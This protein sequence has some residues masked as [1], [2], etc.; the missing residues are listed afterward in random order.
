MTR[1]RNRLLHSIGMITFLLASSL[2]TQAQSSYSITDLGIRGGAGLN[3]LGQ[4]TGGVSTP[5]GVR[6]YRWTDA[7]Y[8][9]IAEASEFLHLSI[10]NSYGFATARTYFQHINNM[11]QVAGV[12]QKNSTTIPEFGYVWNAAGTNGTILTTNLGIQKV[13]TEAFGINDT[14]DVVGVESAHRSNGN[15]QSPIFW[16]LTGASYTTLRI[17]NLPGSTAGYAWDVNN[18]RQVVGTS[19]SNA[20]VWSEAAGLTPLGRLAGHNGSTGVNAIN[21]A[22]Y[23]VGSTQ[24]A[25]LPTGN[26]VARAYL[27]LPG[28]DNGTDFTPYD[29]GGAWT[30]SRASDIN[31]VTTTP[32]S[33]GVQI[34]FKIAG[35][36]WGGSGTAQAVIWDVSVTRTS[37][38]QSVNWTMTDMNTRIDP[39]SGWLL[40]EARA[41]NDN[42]QVLCNSVIG[43]Q[44]HPI[45]LTPQ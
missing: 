4:V 36:V 11:G 24:Y 12:V 6:V 7:N 43:N 26:V 37:A 39:A 28:T 38:G 19:G 23:A 10:P 16:K 27:W 18:A 34:T 9:G 3:N 14:G 41:V 22:G 20:F 21:N 29:L 45:L 40:T 8:N 2:H 15:I 1:N 32:I 13:L 42:G 5:N 30:D 25:T 31:N 44:G 17:P 35:Q 33:D